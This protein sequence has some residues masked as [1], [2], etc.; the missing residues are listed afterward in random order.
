MIPLVPYAIGFI[1]YVIFCLLTFEM[2]SRNKTMTKQPVLIF[3]YLYYSILAWYVI[4]IVDESTLEQ[5]VQTVIYMIPGGFI[6]LY[7]YNT[8]IKPKDE[9]LYHQN[10]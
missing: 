6:V 8:S 7:Y 1:I 3:F 4:G 2:Y 5:I 9:R 10:V